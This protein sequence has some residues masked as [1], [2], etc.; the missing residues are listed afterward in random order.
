[1]YRY[2]RDLVVGRT[3]GDAAIV[4]KVINPSEAHVRPSILVHTSIYCFMIA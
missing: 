4:M 1:V 3:M 2:M